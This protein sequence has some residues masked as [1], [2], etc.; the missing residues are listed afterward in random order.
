MKLKVA[1]F[2]RKHKLFLVVAITV[3]VFGFA[4]FLQM[5]LAGKAC[6]LMIE[7]LVERGLELFTTEE[8]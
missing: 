5:D 2:L 8:E 6:E 7:P 1:K 3:L 4:K